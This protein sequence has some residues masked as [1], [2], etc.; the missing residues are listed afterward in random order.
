MPRKAKQDSQADL[1]AAPGGAAA[2][3]RALTLLSAFQPGDK[4]LGL[5][6]LADRSGLYKSTVLRLLASLVHAE[7]V[8]R[9]PNGRYRLGSEVARLYSVY[10]RSFTL[11]GVVLPVLRELVEHTGESAAFHI[12]QGSRRVCLYRVDSPHPVR[13]HIKEGDL[14]PL[15]R[16]AGGQV[17]LAFSGASGERFDQIRR[18][19]MVMLVGDR[20]P[21]LAGISAP[22]FDAAGALAGAVTLTMPANRYAEGHGAAVLHASH[23][24]TRQLGGTPPAASQAPASASPSPTP[25][26]RLTSEKRKT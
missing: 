20:V 8:Q 12:R 2:V 15:E 1:A 22:A 13:D 3:D 17:L 11:E 19:G 5:P 18:D 23:Q 16:G 14:L 26:A 9:M 6:E 24:I 10:A 25:R 7:L 21:D 4:D